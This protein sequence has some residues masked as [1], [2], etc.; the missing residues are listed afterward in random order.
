L[1]SGLQPRQIVEEEMDSYTTTNSLIALANPPMKDYS[2][3]ESS[4]AGKM[5]I[6]V[7]VARDVQPE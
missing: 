1:Q 2:L 5:L 4:F 7:R 6:S 3:V